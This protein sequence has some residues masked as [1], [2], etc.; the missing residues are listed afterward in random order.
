MINI[1]LVI[2]SSFVKNLKKA[3]NMMKAVRQEKVFIMKHL[4]LTKR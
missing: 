4:Q 2:W 1:Q 3:N